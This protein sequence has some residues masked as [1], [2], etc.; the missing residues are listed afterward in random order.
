MAYLA[1]INR[2]V[3]DNQ[4]IDKSAGCGRVARLPASE[5]GR[6]LGRINEARG[7]SAAFRDVP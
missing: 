2:L 3:D 1:A 7:S 5:S 6:A 4:T